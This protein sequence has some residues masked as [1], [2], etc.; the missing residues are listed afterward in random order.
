VTNL[1]LCAELAENLNFFEIG[2][3]LKDVKVSSK[4]LFTL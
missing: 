1:F 2:V 3:Y 4:L